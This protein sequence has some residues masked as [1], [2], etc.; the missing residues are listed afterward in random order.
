MIS[1]ENKANNSLRLLPHQNSLLE[2]FFNPTSKRVILLK[3]DVG[4]GKATALATL[5]SRLLREVPNARVLFLVPAA[6]RLHFVEML[7]KAQTSVLLVDRY[8]FREMLDS[9]S[10]EDLWPKGMAAVL[11]L[12]FAK[13]ADIR[14]SLAET[15]WDL[16]I[17]D[18]AHSIRGFRA[19]AFRKVE[20]SADRVILATATIF[21]GETFDAFPAEDVTVVEWRRDQVIDQD[22]KP[23]GLVPRPILHEVPF[24]LNLAE[25]GLRS[26]VID[27]CKILAGFRG[28]QDFSVIT[29]LRNLESSPAALE[30]ALRRRLVAQE[31][32]D[33]LLEGLEEE[34]PEDKIV[35]PLNRTNVEKVSEIATRILQDIE[36]I[37]EDSKLDAFGRLLNELETKMPLGRICVL[38]QYLGTLYYL[39][40]EI[41]GRGMAFQLLHGGMSPEDRHKSLRLF[42]DSEVI[43]VATIAVM[44]EG[45]ALPEVT[46]LILYDVP[47]SKI[48]LQQVLGRFDRFGRRSQLTVHVLTPSNISN[49][50]IAA[51]S[52]L[53][54]DLLAM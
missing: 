44:T 13:Q 49:G 22:G 26:T 29:L 53:L 28:M 39:A 5:A 27:L 37:G 47:G 38:T 46:D 19:E 11:S 32:A 52:D 34:M 16:V 4:L 45:L 15:H 1:A 51:H 50:F 41:E 18:E 8:R 43:L 35:E 2:T 36:E 40:A 23:L 21:E 54:R 14:D 17:A 9:T 3:G 24:S 20:A 6:L 42:L 10:G 12:D 31:E 48:M 25:L 33:Y 7:G 30:S